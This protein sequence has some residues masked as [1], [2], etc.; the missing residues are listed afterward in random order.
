MK[1]KLRHRFFKAI[2]VD[3]I[4]RKSLSV[5]VNVFANK[6]KVVRH[7]NGRKYAFDAYYGLYD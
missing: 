5:H 3:Q 6:L 2:Y 1:E 4:P 7:R